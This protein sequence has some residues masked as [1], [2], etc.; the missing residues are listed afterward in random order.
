MTSSNGGELN[1]RQQIGRNVKAEITRAGAHQREIAAMLGIGRG[2]MFR[3]ITGLAPWPV[4]QLEQVADY[5]KVP[6]TAF[7]ERSHT[8]H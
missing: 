8:R 7:L 4:D 5:L 3:R 2:Q 1:R 6:I